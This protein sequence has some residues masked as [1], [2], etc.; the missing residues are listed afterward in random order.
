I[1]AAVVL[2]LVGVGLIL[3]PNDRGVLS[4]LPWQRIVAAEILILSLF[5][6]AHLFAPGAASFELAVACSGGGYLRWALSTHLTMLFG[7]FGTRILS[8]LIA[9]VAFGATETVSLDDCQRGLESL[10]ARLKAGI[11]RWEAAALAPRSFPRLR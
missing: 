6:L 1:P 7:L 11:E 8:D 10:Q 4:R 2:I 5:S 3:L 9:L